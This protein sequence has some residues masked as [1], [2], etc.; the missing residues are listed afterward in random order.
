MERPCDVCGTPYAAKR[1]TSRYCST[2]CR[3]RASRGAP[4]VQLPTPPADTP[5]GSV[6]AA[7]LRELQEAGRDDTAL[8][9][10]CLRLASRLD[11]PQTDTGSAMAAVA[12]QLDTMLREATKG[13]AAR[14]APGAL[15]DELAARRAKQA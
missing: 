2:R 13:A 14:T 8:G 3:T 7:T 1:A 5:S 15:Q 12:K 11:D 10:A 4:V 9:Q 6:H